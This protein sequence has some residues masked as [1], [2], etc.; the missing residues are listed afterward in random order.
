MSTCHAFIAGAAV[1]M[2]G[3]ISS[4]SHP[5]APNQVAIEHEVD[6]YYTSRGSYSFGG[7]DGIAEAFRKTA[8]HAELSDQYDP[9][10]HGTFVRIRA[11]SRD[12]SLGGKVYGY[13]SVLAFLGAFPFY[14]GDTGY[15]L[16]YEIFHEGRL[17]KKYAY[18][19]RR[20]MFV[21]LPALPFSW[22]SAV[23]PGEAE[24]TRATT[25]RFFADATGDH[26]L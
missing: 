15:D 8:P 1:L 20:H 22:I 18:T 23:T 24:A 26:T 12:M 17:A 13:L 2:S 21:W 10:S 19:I 9:P 6:T 4:I 3:C 7:F 5:D 14:N 16:V 25:M 11:N